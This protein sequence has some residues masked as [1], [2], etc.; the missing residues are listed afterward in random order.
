MSNC[1]QRG[2]LMTLFVGLIVSDGLF[3]LKIPHFGIDWTCQCKMVCSVILPQGLF[4]CWE[5]ALVW[6]ENFCAKLLVLDCNGLWRLMLFCKSSLW[7]ELNISSLFQLVVQSFI[8]KWLVWGHNGF[9]LLFSFYNKTSC[10]QLKQVMRNHY[11]PKQAFLDWNFHSLP[12][13]AVA[14]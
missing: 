1:W 3:W 7:C 10:H 13:P 5:L 8:V 2:F 6:N 4:Y 14:D 12:K 11:K 9:W